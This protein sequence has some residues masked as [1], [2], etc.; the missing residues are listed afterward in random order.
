MN[1]LAEDERRLPDGLV[2]KHLERH[3]GDPQQSLAAVNRPGVLPGDFRHFAD[4]DVEASLVHLLAAR[5]G[6]DPNATTPES[7]GPAPPA[8]IRYRILRPHAR[9]ALG[10]E[11]AAPGDVEGGRHLRQVPPLISP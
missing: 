2:R 8:G 9:G 11:T 4:A 5:T 3:G 10:P 1:K 6:T 7:A